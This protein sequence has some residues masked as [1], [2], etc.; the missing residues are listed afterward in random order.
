MANLTSI[1]LSVF[2]ISGLKS[3][4]VKN[5]GFGVAKRFFMSC[6]DLI[7]DFSK[8]LQAIGIKFGTHLNNRIVVFS[9]INSKQAAAYSSN[10]PQA[11]FRMGPKTRKIHCF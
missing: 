9:M 8:T 4:Q 5:L 10:A 2:E 11:A 7:P 6:S 1:A 3:E